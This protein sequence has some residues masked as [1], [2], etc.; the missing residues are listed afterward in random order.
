[1][2]TKHMRMRIPL[3]LGADS[4]TMVL[5]FGISLV[6][7]SDFHRFHGIFAGIRA[8][9]QDFRRDQLM[10]VWFRYPGRRQLRRRRL[11][12]AAAKTVVAPKRGSQSSSQCRVVAMPPPKPLPEIKEPSK[13][14]F[15]GTA[16]REKKG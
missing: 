5:Y 11:P 13:D 12:K 7:P 10:L 6:I 3:G 16:K 8:Q 15:T 9:D 4:R 1:M 14:G 2:K